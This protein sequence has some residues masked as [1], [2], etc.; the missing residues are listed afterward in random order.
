M[1]INLNQALSIL[2]DGGVIA[3]PTEAIYGLGCRYDDDKA[4]SRILHL[5]QRAPEKGLIVLINDLKQLSRLIAKPL[6]D[7][8]TRLTEQHWPGPFTFLI[9]KHASLSKQLT[10]NHPCVAIRYTDH[11]IAAALC[12][13]GPIVSTSA[14]RQGEAPC[15]S[16]EELEQVFGATIDGLVEG[17]LGKADKPS[18][19]IDLYTGEK[20][21]E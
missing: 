12:A 6:T 17:N 16:P 21:R 14:N 8:E 9:E 18:T 3:Y 7:K 11:P 4:I 15:L 20:V 19:I 1:H 13:K 2:K 10:G 5:K